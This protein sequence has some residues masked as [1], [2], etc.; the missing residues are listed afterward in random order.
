MGHCPEGPNG[1]KVLPLHWL[2]DLYRIDKCEDLSFE[3]STTYVG[4]R[5]APEYSICMEDHHEA[6]R[7]GVAGQAQDG[8]GH[9]ELELAAPVVSTVLGSLGGGLLSAVACSEDLTA[10]LAE[11]EDGVV[12]SWVASGRRHG[13]ED[14]CFEPSLYSHPSWDQNPC[15]GVRNPNGM[16]LPVEAGDDERGKARSEGQFEDLTLQVHAEKPQAT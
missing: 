6:L 10:V 9:V 15:L 16:N 5:V 3:R 11:E 12:S 13:C 4:G 2:L 7:G 1:R 14:N 8:L